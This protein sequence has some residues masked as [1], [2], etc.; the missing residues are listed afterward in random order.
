MATDCIETV[1]GALA[2]V[3]LGKKPTLRTQTLRTS[4]SLESPAVPHSDPNT[5]IPTLLL[6]ILIFRSLTPRPP[7]DST[8]ALRNTL[9]NLTF[10]ALTPLRP[11]SYRTPSN[12][13]PSNPNAPNPKPSVPSHWGA[14][15]P[16]RDPSNA[17]NP[18]IPSPWEPKPSKL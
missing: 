2:Q 10:R 5:S 9:R 14:N 16:N 17:L 6:R 15:L 4:L 11:N 1:F 8:Q 3:S 13:N 7:N 18:S 12:P